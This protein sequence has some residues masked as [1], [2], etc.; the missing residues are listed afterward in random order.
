[1][2]VAHAVALGI[3]AH[4]GGRQYSQQRA[5]ARCRA[6]GTAAWELDHRKLHHAWVDQ[7]RFRTVVANLAGKETKRVANAQMMRSKAEYTTS[8]TLN[9]FPPAIGA[10]DRAPPPRCL[11][12]SSASLR[13]RQTQPI[14]PAAALVYQGE[15]LAENVTCYEDSTLATPVKGHGLH[16]SRTHK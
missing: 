10:A 14:G 2:D 12:R 15:F 9:F 4:A 6:A 8:G 16:L 7:Q 3:V 1:M 13:S 5:T 11:E